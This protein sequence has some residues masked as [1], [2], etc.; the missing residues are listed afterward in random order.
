MAAPRT[1][2][3]L[4]KEMQAHCFAEADLARMAAVTDFVPAKHEELTPEAQREAMTGA[5]VILTGW[6]TLEITPEML[7]AAPDLKLMC[8]SAGSVKHLVTDEFS[9]RGIRVCSAASALA[10]GV[11]E[12]AF[13]LMLCSMKATWQAH[14]MTLGGRWDREPLQEWI[15]EPYDATVG[16]VAAS[17]VGRELIRL[18]KT[19]PLKTILLCDPYVDAAQAE[20]LGVEKVELS[21]LMRRSDVVQLCAPNTPETKHLI[22]AEN[23]TLLRDKAIFINTS[24]GALID[25]AALIAELQQGRLLAC[26]DVTDPEP[27]EAGSPLYTLPNCVLTPHIAGAVKENTKRQGALVADEVVAYTAGQSF[28]REVSLDNLDRLA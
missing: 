17:F 9:A 11:A 1:V 20:A 28:Q 21:E 2:M 19:L 10:I 22:N 24:R 13:G 7:D 8:H 12:Y 16:V 25:E 18:C 23:L 14:A 27:P 26:L 15:C 5:E 3:L 4:T 6:T